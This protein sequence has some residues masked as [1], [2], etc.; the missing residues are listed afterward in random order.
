MVPSA[1]ESVRSTKGL[2]PARHRSM[3]KS[4]RGDTRTGEITRRARGGR[5]LGQQREH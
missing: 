3:Q 1:A 2:A 5:A 4:L